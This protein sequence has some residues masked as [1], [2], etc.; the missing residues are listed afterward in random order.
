VTSGLDG[1]SALGAAERIAH[2]IAGA[3]VWKDERCNWVGA[4]PEEGQD[5]RTTLSFRALGADLYGGSAGVGLFLAEVAEASGD[6]QLRRTALGAL[7]HAISRAGDLPESTRAGLY[8]GRPGVALALALSAAALDEPDMA[9]AARAVASETAGPQPA[10]ELDLMSGSAGAVV[11]LLALRALLGEENLPGKE[12]LPDDESLPGKEDLPGEESL[13]ETAVLHGEALLKSA[14]HSEAG[15]CWPSRTMPGTPG[16]TGLSHGAAGV[17]VA[18][19]ELAAATD[20]ERYREAANAAFAYER[21]L[22]D[23]AAR[24]WPDLRSAATGAGGQ[25]GF[26]TFW[27][28]GAPGG[29]LARLRALELGGQ[30]ELREEACAGLATTEAW[31]GSALSSGT[32]NYSLCHGL[33]GCAEILVEGGSLSPSAPRLA[34]SVASTGIEAYQQRGLP[35]PSGAYGGATPCLFLGLAGIGRFYLK[36]ARPGLPSLLLVR[37]VPSPA[38]DEG[39]GGARAQT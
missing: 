17:A 3:A 4:M 13:L 7:R 2:E 25:A 22:Y 28:H 23:P 37:P 21:A 33:A 31:V 35:W 27:C 24:N 10:G 1:A 29:A 20:D 32:V 34:Q 6:E 11:G 15:L 18:L 14:Q 9:A 19:L 26:A 5:G 12:S 38:P 30:E 39:G 36:L 16:L 8:A